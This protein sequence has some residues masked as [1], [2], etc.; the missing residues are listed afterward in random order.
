MVDAVRDRVEVSTHGETWHVTAG[1][2]TSALS[3]ARERF[4]E[5]VV[6]SRTDRG[7]WWPRVT[8]VVTDDP[9]YAASAPP[10]DDLAHPVPPVASETDPAAEVVASDVGDSGMPAVLEAMFARQDAPL[11]IPRQRR[12]H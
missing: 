7:R 11:P 9:A 5:P 4:D 8:I 10:L 3:Y 12:R 6:L 2:F 1:S